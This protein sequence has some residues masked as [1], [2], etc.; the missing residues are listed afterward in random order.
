MADTPPVTAIE[1]QM[2]GVEHGLRLA[3]RF[4]VAYRAERVVAA[5]D[6]ELKQLALSRYAEY[7]RVRAA[8]DYDERTS[9]GVLRHE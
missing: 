9:D 8:D 6:A 5:I 4:A 7:E 1:A 2:R 3:R